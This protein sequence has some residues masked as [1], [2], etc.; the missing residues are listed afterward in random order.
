[1]R[2]QPQTPLITVRNAMQCRFEAGQHRTLPFGLKLI[3]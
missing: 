3:S 1:M 2:D